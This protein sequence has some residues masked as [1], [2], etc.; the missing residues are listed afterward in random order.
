MERMISG[1]YWKLG[2]SLAFSQF[3][4]GVAIK[5]KRRLRVNNTDAAVFCCKCIQSSKPPAGIGRSESKQSSASAGGTA[6]HHLLL[7]LPQSGSFNMPKSIY[8]TF[9]SRDI[10]TFY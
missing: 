1:F 9:L 3:K 6:E 2:P 8:L 7:H 10:F 5:N 4:A